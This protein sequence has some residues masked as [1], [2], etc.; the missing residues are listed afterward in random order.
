MKH[1]NKFKFNIE[2]KCLV[3]NIS[4]SCH[5]Q[6]TATECWKRKFVHQPDA[7]YLQDDYTLLFTFSSFMDIPHIFYKS[8]NKK[9]QQCDMHAQSEYSALCLS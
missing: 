7:A 6:N 3:I 5:R 9:K 4:I 2:Q 1:K 8:T